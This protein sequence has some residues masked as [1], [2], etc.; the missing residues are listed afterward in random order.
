VALSKKS[1][2][3]REYPVVKSLVLRFQYKDK[4]S[5]NYYNW[6]CSHFR[7]IWWNSLL[8]KLGNEVK[9]VVF[10][11]KCMSK[12]NDKRSSIYWSIP[13]EVIIKRFNGLLLFVGNEERS[14]WFYENWFFGF[15]FKRL[16][17]LL[18]VVVLCIRYPKYYQVWFTRSDCCHKLVGH[19][20]FRWTRRL[21]EKSY[22]KLENIVNFQKDYSHLVL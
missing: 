16:D 7:S 12:G 13:T 1:W 2:K 5:Y 4:I 21:Y 14:N 3:P 19:T 8:Q 18:W 10:K 11:H 15:Q 9:R 17:T 22:S 6:S 20:H